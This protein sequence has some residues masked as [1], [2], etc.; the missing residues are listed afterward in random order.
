MTPTFSLTKKRCCFCVSALLCCLLVP[1]VGF[2]E[3]SKQQAVSISVSP[4]QIT[5]GGGNRRQQ[6]L[7]TG[8]S[9]T[10]KEFDLT[11]QATI[12]VA[13]P[14]IA[15]ID[16]TSLVGLKEGKT[17]VVIRSASQVVRLPVTVAN[18][19]SYPPVHFENDIMP[20][21]T[22]LGCN[23]GGC[24]GKQ[25]GQNGFKLSIFG[26]D[27]PGDFAALVKDARGRRVF[28][29]SPE[30]SLLITKALGKVAHGGGR[31]M[32]AGSADH[33]V[34]LEWV[35]QSMPWGNDN[36]PRL[37]TIEVQPINRV[38]DASSSQQILVTAIFSDGSRRDVTAAAAYTS[39]S[40]SIADVDVDGRIYSGKTPGEAAV[41]VN[42]MGQIA[43][44][45]VFI[46]RPGSSFKADSVPANNAIDGLVWSKLQKMGIAPSQLSD[47]QMFLRRVSLD[48]IGSLP[49]IE[50]TRRFLTD[51]SPDKRSRL[52]DDLLSRK[53]FADYWALKW[54]DV[55]MVDRD[56]LGER[57]AYSFHRWLRK[58]IA[59]NRPYDE[60]VRELITASGNS[61]KNGPVNFY[62]ALKK[63]EDLAR[64]VSQAFLG[65]RIDCAQCHHH[66]FDRWGRD[67]FYGMV[68]FFNNIQRKK[69]SGDRDLIYSTG[70]K[71]SKIPYSDTVVATRPLGGEAIEG[72]PE[73]DPRIPFANWLTS[74][75]NPWFARMVANRIWKHFLGRGLVEPEDDLRLTNPA[76]NEPLLA[77]L[78]QQ[79][80]KSKFDLKQTMRLILNSRVYQ[81][82]S[83][84]NKTNADDEQNFSHYLVKRLP[85]HVLLDAISRATETNEN[86]VGMPAGTQAIELWDN[87]LPSYF[88]ATF[89][90]S[91]RKSAC[92][93]GRSDA[94]TMAQAL[95]LMNAPE[96]DQKISAVEGRV[97]KILASGSSQKQIIDELCLATLS[98][99]PNEK[100]RKIAQQLFSQ[101]SRQLAAEDFLWT[102]L[103]SYDFLMIR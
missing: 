31:R 23:S 57:G 94:P 3:N 69:L 61:A 47:D 92:E 20:V 60:W 58:Q 72:Q 91:Q 56:A 26:F 64:S 28:P 82:S 50:E 35:R 65:I 42:Y 73:I 25:G 95:H 12:S 19:N 16:G 59:T 33:Q 8:K 34:L 83:V 39:N 62:R 52:I 84:P 96:I 75:E 87:R 22:K 7:V 80:V 53:E 4:Q 93:C 98:R 49:T 45:Q 63:P 29:A 66:P 102:L 55:L 14:S 21:L 70:F 32:Q 90:R 9:S 79:V 100:E 6:L 54:A 17:E 37:Q 99:L 51:A 40:E 46:P 38:M 74:P 41:N 36:T 103:N 71:Q 76:T 18:F 77:Y 11:Q 1:T 43:V 89:G 27:S 67:D 85:S 86:Y 44:V 88:L 68:G 78:E 48:T 97:A 30:Q 5:L 15:T 2:A 13:H 101:E 81:L 10:G 24:H